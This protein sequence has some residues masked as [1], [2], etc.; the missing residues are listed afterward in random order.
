M[1][2]F[3]DYLVY[4]MNHLVSST[5]GILPGTPP[6]YRES[7]IS[8]AISL[9]L[10]LFKRSLI[11][12]IKIVALSL[13]RSVKSLPLP[14]FLELGKFTSLAYA[15]PHGRY[16]NL[17]LSFGI[18]ASGVVR[19]RFRV[20]ADLSPAKFLASAGTESSHPRFWTIG[21]SSFNSF[22]EKTRMPRILTH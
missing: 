14:L 17:M 7:V 1:L 13:T 15:T 3:A 22:S 6:L 5:F 9:M 20:P 11:S 8:F 21:R 10:N 18:I 4:L 19:M 2:P 12:L 16:I